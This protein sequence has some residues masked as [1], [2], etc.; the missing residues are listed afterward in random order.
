MQHPTNEPNESNRRDPVDPTLDEALTRLLLDEVDDAERVSLEATLDTDPALRAHFEERRAALAMLR[1]AAGPTP[2][3][4]DTRRAAILAAD[5]GATDGVGATARSGWSLYSGLAAALLLFL[6]GWILMPNTL[7]TR[8]E[9]SGLQNQT[10]SAAPAPDPADASLASVDGIRAAEKA[11]R[12]GGGGVRYGHSATPSDDGAVLVIGYDQENL[13]TT[14]ISI[15]PVDLYA[16]S[17]G[18]EATV[19]LVLSDDPQAPGTPVRFA[20]VEAH[21]VTGSASGGL[22]SS[23]GGTSATPATPSL[24]VGGSPIREVGGT[25]TPASK[26]PAIDRL[27]SELEG[28]APT[29]Q[30]GLHDGA[31]RPDGAL[32]PDV[33]T[34]VGYNLIETTGEEGKDATVRRVMENLEQGRTADIAGITLT[35]EQR[36]LVETPG[37]R[38]RDELL[39]RL[40]VE[41][42]AKMEAAL[43]EHRRQADET[44]VTAILEGLRRRSGESPDAMYFRFWGDHAFVRADHDPLS[45]FG[46]DV[47]TASY[48]LCRNYLRNGNLPPKAAVRTEEFV[49]AFPR[50]LEAPT[51]TDLALHMELA[52]SEFSHRDGVALLQVGVKAREV[53]DEDRKPIALTI[54]LDVSGSMQQENRLELVKQAIL[55]LLPELDGRDTIGLVAF[56]T[57]GRVVLEPVSA[58]D[59]DAIGAA[60]RSLSPEGS[61]NAQEGL[62]LG[63]AMAERQFRDGA[64]NRVALFSDGV[65]NSGITDVESLLGRTADAR[66]RGIQMNTFGCGMGNHN[67]T[68]LEQLADRGDG[69]CAYLDS[70]KEAQDHFRRDLAGTFETVA[71]DAKIQ[72]E[73]H[74]GA[75]LRYRQVGY[76]NRA[77]ADADFRN[78]AVDAGE[79]GAGHE[80]V[81]LY[82]VE[83]V[84]NADGPIATARVRYHS[85]DRDEVVEIEQTAERGEIA[86]FHDATPHFRLAATVAAFAEVLRDS[87][88]ARE[89][90]LGEIDEVARP[91]LALDTNED[92]SVAEFIALVRQ[93]ES[94]VEARVRSELSQVVDEVKRNHYLRARIED[95]LVEREQADSDDPRR[96]AFREEL[97]RLRAENQNLERRLRDLI[98]G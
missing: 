56:S 92:D 94:L 2:R 60:L 24:A 62:D 16:S 26:N 66:A 82:E 40:R 14:N 39:D 27:V 46:I 65:A 36:Q 55:T 21:S 87:T 58:L 81:A 74:P 22:V 79:V 47:D 57:N 70:L 30:F 89:T 76:E 54:V 19:G 31:P 11:G 96:A 98:V 37:K 38:G 63:Y 7:G 61:T 13:T 59:V 20:G 1:T 97:E 45:T 68:L 93:A 10:Q 85:V 33:V 80:V 91:L 48:S 95:R 77:I 25:T 6:V 28:E 32:H 83:L 78:D 44:R 90:T 8:D 50:N 88:W 49:N 53:A 69:V 23:P 35:E 43:E 72:V 75:V 4:S 67:D 73:F 29:S 64:N 41:L 18:P 34:H 15:P 51:E 9:S 84:P 3:L 86:E 71:R 12:G 17:A 52:T 5:A 42:E